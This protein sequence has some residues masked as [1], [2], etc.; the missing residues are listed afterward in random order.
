V[1]TVGAAQP[2]RLR[3]PRRAHAYEH[4][5]A[6]RNRA[7]ERAVADPVD[8][9]QH[10]TIHSQRLARTD[11]NPARGSIEPHDVKRTA[12]G[13]AQSLA[14]ADGEVRDPLMA[15]QQAAREIDNIARLHGVRLQPADDVGIT[16]ARHEA[17][18]L[19]VLL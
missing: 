2:G 4:L 5:K 18:V 17:D 7:V 13:D 19:A 1:S 8:V 10:D 6:T 3:H 12:Q 9:T 14:L 15:P 16:P 11:N